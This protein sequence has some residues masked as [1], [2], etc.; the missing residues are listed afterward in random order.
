MDTFFLA[1]LAARNALLFNFHVASEGAFFF[2]RRK[3]DF[4]PAIVDYVRGSPLQLTSS[5]CGE[6]FLITR[7]ASERTTRIRLDATRSDGEAK[8]SV[9]IAGGVIYQVVPKLAVFAFGNR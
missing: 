1:F 2:L 7:V 6:P 4:R 5:T 3:I 9:R 8:G